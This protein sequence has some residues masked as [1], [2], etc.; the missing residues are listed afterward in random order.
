MKGYLTSY[1]GMFA[2][3]PQVG[4]AVTR[5]EIP[6]IQRDY[7]QGRLSEDVSEIRTTFL[8]ALLLAIG[9][10]EPVGLDFVYGKVEA[11]T[12][13]P[14]DGQQR[15]TTLFLLH[16]YVASRAETLETN[17]DWTCFSYATRASARRF[18]ERLCEHALP[19]SIAQ[20]SEWIVDQPWYLYVWRDDPTINSMLVM[21]DSIHAEVLR[22]RPDFEPVEAWERLTDSDSP[23]ISFYL[24]PLDDMDSDEDLYIKMNSRGKPLTPFEH[25][26][27]R[28][29]QD[30]AHSARAS[31]FAH[32]IDGTWSDLLWPMHG[33]DFIVDDEFMRYIDYLTELCEFREDREVA[34]WRLGPRARDIFGGGNARA[35]E[36]VDFLFDA[37]DCW[38]TSDDIVSTFNDT[39]S[40]AL[41]GGADYDSSKVV[42]FGSTTA[43]L[44]ESCV[45]HYRSGVDKNPAFSRPHGLLLYGVL[46]HRIG[47]TADF[48]RRIRVLRNLIAA[49]EDEIRRSAMPALLADV[50]QIIVEG[51]LDAVAKFSTNQLIDEKL[52]QAMLDENPGL[53]SAL[54]RLEDHSILRGTLS[55]FEF[56]PTFFASRARAFEAAFAAPREWTKLTGALLATGDYQRQPRRWTAWQFGTGSPRHES[57]WRSLLTNATREG[58]VDV[59]R[60]LGELLDGLAASEHEP[61]GHFVDVT[62]TWLE[63]CERVGNLDWRYYLVKYPLMRSGESGIYYGV[64]GQ[65]GYMLCMLHKTQR[66]SLYRDPILLE[67]WRQSQVGD[68]AKNPW[69]TGYETKERWLS[70][71]NSGVALRCVD[72]GYELRAPDSEGPFASFEGVCRQHG[73]KRHDAGV[74]SLE[75]DQRDRNGVLVDSV[76]RVTKGAELLR[77]LV[78]A[79]L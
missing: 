77:A 65:L 22:L 72:T 33:G 16:W 78:E 8:E 55:A 75:I 2:E 43:N 17:A 10:G 73:V 45:H 67:V 1:V 31:E 74:F 63:E 54:F 38:G 40:V 46:L 7:A 48:G 69:F 39:F 28:F 58:L 49:S 14:L 42:P 64:D 34:E 20:P 79:G 68:R 26:K 25:F 6:L 57:V 37:F 56:D 52:K 11:G 23:V 62:A 3:N 60:V 70:L 66:N 5:T 15:L 29:E 12:F 24:L 41:P 21:L 19:E 50:E 4:P 59:R 71:V 51:N 53:S 32:K 61:G 9:G 35:A 27:A 36:H 76:D 30:I 47:D 13:K 44:F 18:C